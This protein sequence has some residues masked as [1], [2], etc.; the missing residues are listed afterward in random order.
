MCLIHILFCSEN[1]WEEIF[2]TINKD[3]KVKNTGLIKIIYFLT[4]IKLLFYYMP[5]KQIHYHIIS[6]SYYTMKHE[7]LV[8][9]IALVK[10]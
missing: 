9:L 1:T 10:K 7:I 8:T 4:S 6:I 2:T 5:R 3:L